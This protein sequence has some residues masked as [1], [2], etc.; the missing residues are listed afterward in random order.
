LRDIDVAAQHA[1]VQQRYYVRAGKL[2]LCPTSG[3]LD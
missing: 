1:A 3:G 2:L